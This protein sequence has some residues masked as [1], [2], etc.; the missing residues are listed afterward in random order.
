MPLG[1]FHDTIAA[2][3]TPEG[4][5]A[6][7]IVR[8]SGPDAIGIVS[9]MVEDP[10][11]LWVAKSASS[12]YAKI[13][14]IDDVVI[15]I[16]RAPRSFSGEDLCEITPHGSPII[17]RQIL[18]LLYAGGA[19]QAEPGE[20]SRRAFF[21]GKI[22]IED[23]ELISVKVD[24]QSV[25]EL[26]GSE[27]ALHEKFERLHGAYEQL[28]SLIAHVDAEI[29]FGESDHIQI[30]DFDLRVESVRASLAQLLRDSLTRRANAGFFTVALTGPPNV[31]KSSVF[32]A[33]LNF[34]RSIVSDIP[35]TTRDY[36]EAF[37]NIDG[38]RVKL[39][40]TAGVRDAE[41]FIEGRGIELG[42]N[43]AQHAD[44]SL[45]VTEPGDRL[46]SMPNGSLLLHNKRDLDGWSEG[47]SVSAITGEGVSRIHGWLAGELRSRSSEY[48]MLTLS[49]L[50]QSTI[51]EVLLSLSGVTLES[52]PAILSDDLRRCASGISE[53][54]G[55]NISDN[56]LD[57]IFAKMCIGK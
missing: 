22:G 21:N 30:K 15:H 36:V 7:A 19:R 26:R 45:R 48:N 23:A 2:I 55:E 5:S 40:D 43:A 41:E 28:I 49:D 38:F 10:A 46:P 27:L 32:N 13:T 8:I 9:R 3:A 37:I 57:Y 31:G 54:L 20:F 39:I 42:A 44:I 25:H 1:L 17:A 16:N 52:E 47:L 6:L 29:D 12:V 4:R 56:S 14:D 11:D 51:S 50:E 33:L 34:E 18:E 24:A 53:L 35:G